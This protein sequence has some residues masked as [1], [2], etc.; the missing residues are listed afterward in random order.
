MNQH[1]DPAFDADITEVIPYINELMRASHQAYLN[2]GTWPAELC[3][4]CGGTLDEHSTNRHHSF[5]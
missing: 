1:A 3:K 4:R 2:G 5:E